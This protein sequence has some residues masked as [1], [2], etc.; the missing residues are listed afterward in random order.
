MP[1]TSALKPLY[2]SL[3]QIAQ[4]VERRAENS[5]VASSSLA[6]SMLSSDVQHIIP[7]FTESSHLAVLTGPYPCVI[8]VLHLAGLVSLA[9]TLWSV[10]RLSVGSSSPGN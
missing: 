10:F 7:F 9:N 3:A 2:Y 8:L 6:L 4:S 1:S 5:E